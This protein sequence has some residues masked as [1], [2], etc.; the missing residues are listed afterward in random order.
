VAAATAALQLNQGF[1]F[2]GKC[3][4]ISYAR[5]KS[6]RISKMDGTYKPKAKRVKLQAADVNR[7]LDEVKKIK[8]EALAA[9]AITTTTGE[10]DTEA[11][12]AEDLPA[13]PPPPPPPTE[14]TP[15]S[16]ILFAQD[17]PPECTEVMLT[18][19]FRQ[20]PG[21]KEVRVPRQGLSF[22][23][24]ENEAQATVALKAMNGFKLTQHDS[25]QLTYGKV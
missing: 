14:T 3:L 21:F 19:L 23:E 7:S 16:N 25:L 6:D 15:P 17:I 24:Y 22:V 1:D 9:T 11:K 18:M 20:Y 13:V 8:E 12:S 5:E 10:Q 2:F 4:A